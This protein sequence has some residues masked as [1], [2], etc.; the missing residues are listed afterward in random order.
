MYFVL[1]WSGER[2][3]RYREARNSTIKSSKTPKT[4]PI[5]FI[6]FIWFFESIAENLQKFSSIT[7]FPKNSKG[8]S[9][10]THIIHR[11]RPLDN[12]SLHWARNSHGLHPSRYPIW[13]Y[14][15]LGIGIKHRRHY[16]S[17]RAFRKNWDRYPYG[18]K[19]VTAE[20]IQS[21][22]LEIST[23]GAHF[24]CDRLR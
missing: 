1:T 14:P 4:F 13:L 12:G 17:S 19:P 3:R 22:N 24:D 8:E 20:A 10:K 5:L 16:F 21:S 9:K 15:T 2:S 23:D 7:Y 6:Q 11:P 18:S